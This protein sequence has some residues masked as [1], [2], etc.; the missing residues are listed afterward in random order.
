VIK[1]GDNFSKIARAHGVSLADLQ[2]VNPGV[3]SSSLKVGQKIKLP[4]K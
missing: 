4:K 3:E 2:A 1:S